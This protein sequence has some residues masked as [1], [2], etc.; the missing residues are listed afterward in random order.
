MRFAH[1]FALLS[2]GVG[3]GFYFGRWSGSEGHGD[4]KGARPGREAKAIENWL[5]SAGD[6][7][8]RDRDSAPQGVGL[9]PLNKVEVLK[10][11]DFLHSGTLSGGESSRAW[12]DLWE[13]LRVSDLPALAAALNEGNARGE[14]RALATVMAV[15]AEEDPVKAWSFAEAMEPARTRRDAMFWV[16]GTWAREDHAAALMKAGEIKDDLLRYQL[17]S[18][19]IGT[20]A[21]KDPALALEIAL[22]GGDSGKPAIV[23]GIFREWLRKDPVAARAAASRLD[24][25][26]AR[27]ASDIIV[28]GLSRS[29]P[30]AAWDYVQGLP[31]DTGR[32]SVGNLQTRVIE[33]WAQSD[34]S[35][36]IAAGLSIPD[37]AKR[38]HAI[39][40]AV[41][42][43]SDSDF[44][45][46][47]NYAVTALEP[48]LKGRVLQGLARRENVRHE[49]VF[50][51]LLE[52]SPTT[53]LFKDSVAI[54]MGRWASTDPQAAAMAA[55]SLSPRDGL[56]WAVG[57]VA[58][59]WAAS[60]TDRQRVLDWTARLPEG[61]VRDT[62]LREAFERWAAQDPAAAQRLLSA[63]GATSNEKAIE[64]LLEGWTRANP[65][66]AARWALSLPE[67]LCPDNAV[68]NAVRSWARSSPTAA[69]P[70]VESVP[71]G[72]RPN[73]TEALVE[74][75]SSRDPE[76]AAGWVKSQPAGPA[77]DAGISAVV[78]V[79]AQDDPE[80]ALAWARSMMN[81]KARL[82]CTEDILQSW[83]SDDP[84]RAK[85]WIA[86]A[87]IPEP[88]RMKLSKEK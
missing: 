9:G 30:Q 15:W 12:A 61:P 42:A 86:A 44:D 54:L 37:L 72:L 58:E 16:L 20:V 68:R 77:K 39:A 25:P 2:L 62:A 57:A 53:P 27:T 50:N 28:E 10:C 52:H 40:S 84:A 60:A 7:A 64:G 66:D 5:A 21:Q 46:A 65:G 56:S 41:Q 47:L 13:R 81:E 71:M 70:F 48:G 36:A 55:L 33:L 1:F 29:D 80:T 19:V 34:P 67:N 11:I 14:N 6:S 79:I 4:V 24:G 26:M 35:S 31:R 23:G 78:E 74:I 18:R 49:A 82:D 87:Q 32:N 22:Q 45:A 43:W 69:A 3:V 63:A 8:G 75:W 76:A 85:A 73:A 88:L 83:L 38:D 51:A 59:E 17:T